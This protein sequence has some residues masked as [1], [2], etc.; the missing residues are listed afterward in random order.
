M[1]LRQLRRQRRAP[2]CAGFAI[3]EVASEVMQDVHLA[4][5]LYDGLQG[6]SEQPERRCVLQRRRRRQTSERI[7]RR[8]QDAEQLLIVLRGVEHERIALRRRQRSRARQPVGV[9]SFD[10]RSSRDLGVAQ[11]LA[12]AVGG[13]NQ[14]G[15]NARG[16]GG[17]H[18]FIPTLRHRHAF[19]QLRL[20]S[21][22]VALRKRG[23]RLA[24]DLGGDVRIRG[25]VGRLCRAGGGHRVPR[26]Y[27][28]GRFDL[29]DADGAVEVAEPIAHLQLAVENLRGQVG[30]AGIATG[31]VRCGKRGVRRFTASRNHAWP[32]RVEILGRRD[33]R[34]QQLVPVI[35]EEDLR[36]LHQGV[37][38]LRILGQGAV[39]HRC[40][41]IVDALELRLHGARI[42]GIHRKAVRLAAEARRRNVVPEGVQVRFVCRSRGWRQV[43]GR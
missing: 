5:T 18:V 36:V 7:P 33:L 23:E 30:G 42:A 28:V 13:R 26:V 3:P 43:P 35:L 12:P 2:H 6:M 22:R 10:D 32:A 20:T 31:G 4:E 39:R 41:G 37:L 25:R 17:L 8:Q 15:L 38:H 1:H 14:L 11:E 24:E 34:G 9:R 40:Q 21:G 27:A 19:A 16:G 29:G